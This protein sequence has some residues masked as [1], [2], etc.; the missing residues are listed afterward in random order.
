[1]IWE[2][3]VTAAFGATPIGAAIAD[4]PVPMSVAPMR[5]ALVNLRIVFPLISRSIPIRRGDK[6]WRKYAPQGEMFPDQN[7]ALSRAP[8]EF[9]CTNEKGL[10]QE[11]LWGF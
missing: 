8:S 3:A 11:P 2:G 7:V 1:V 4:V 10:R 9:E 5:L 6:V